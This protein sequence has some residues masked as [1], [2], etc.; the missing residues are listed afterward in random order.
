[1][2]VTTFATK[3]N[4]SIIAIAAAAALVLTSFAGATPANAA[5]PT[6]N[7]NSNVGMTTAVSDWTI[8]QSNTSG[9]AGLRGYS[10]RAEYRISDPSLI[11]KTLTLTGSVSGMA[12]GQSASFSADLTF[13]GPNDT[14]ARYSNIYSNQQQPVVV[15]A[16]TDSIQVLIYISASRGLD[17]VLLSSATMNPSFELKAGGVSITRNDVYSENYAGA[18][19]VLYLTDQPAFNQA[20]ENAEWSGDA[21][22]REV[23]QQTVTCVDISASSEGDELV[24]NQ[25]RDGAVSNLGNLSWSML[26]NNGFGGSGAGPVVL[27]AGM[28]SSGFMLKVLLY[29]TFTGASVTSG[30]HSS[31]VS[32]THNGVEV[33]APCLLVV[34]TVTPTLTYEAQS[35]NGPS[36]LFA[37]VTDQAFNSQWSWTVFKASDDSVL[38]SGT[39]FGSGRA[40]GLYSCG[41]TGC[42]QAAPPGVP[43]YVKVRKRGYLLSS[44]AGQL[45]AYSAYSQKSTNASIPDPWIS[46]TAPSAGS[47]PGDAKLVAGNIDYSAADFDPTMVNP[48]SSLRVASDGKNGV[49]RGIISVGEGCMSPNTACTATAK[50]LRIGAS[51]VDSTFATGGAT[52]LSIGSY[53]STGGNGFFPDSI[54]PAWYGARNKWSAVIRATD[55]SQNFPQFSYR[56]VTGTFASSTVSTPVNLTSAQLL[57]VCNTGSSGFTN[58]SLTAV[59]APT[60][61]PIFSLSCTRQGQGPFTVIGSRYVTI[62]ADGAVTVIAKLN[63]GDAVADTN[64]TTLAFVANVSASAASDVALTIVGYSLTVTGSGP[65]GYTGAIVARKAVQ[66]KVDGSAVTSNT[67]PYSSTAT[68]AEL[69]KKFVFSRTSSGESSKGFVVSTSNN[70]NSY[71]FATMSADGTITEGDALV[72]DSVEGLNNSSLSFVDGQD[73]GTTGK[74]QV[75][76]KTGTTLVAAATIDLDEKTIDTG[77]VVTYLNSVDP[78]V[79]TFTFLDPQGRVNWMFTSASSKLSL[80]RWNGVAGGGALP[81]GVTV[82]SVSTKFITNSASEV[83]IVGTGLNTNTDTAGKYTVGQSLVSA[84]TRTATKVVIVVPAGSVAGDI[85]IKGTFAGSGATLAAVTRVGA[86]KQAQSVVVTGNVSASWS[87]VNAKTVVTFPAATSVGLTTLVKVDKPAICSVSGQVVTMNAVGVC[88]VTVSSAGDLGTSSTSRATTLTVTRGNLALQSGPTLAVTNNPADLGPSDFNVLN[89]NPNVG[90]LAALTGSAVVFTYSSSDEGICTV[91]ENGNV[92]GIAVGFCVVTSNASAGTNWLAAAVTTTVTVT[93]STSIIPDSLPQEGDGV[94]APKAIVS[95]KNAYVLTN[96][97]SLLVKWDKKTGL[98]TLQSKGVYIGHI[99]AEV[100][101][102]KDGVSYTCVNVFGSTSAL[103]SK[104]AAQRKAAL[105]T[106]TF[107]ASSAACKDASRLNVPGVGGVAGTL[108]D[109]FSAIKKAAKDKKAAATVVGSAKYEALAFSKLKNFTGNVTIKL[110]RYR[111]WPTSMKNLTPGT[112]SAAKKIP[113]TVRLT[114]INLQ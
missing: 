33:S 111:A 103:A 12:A 91:D 71:N 31:G 22:F 92:T 8:G 97:S 67:T 85:E 60:S 79:I 110:T 114:S 88:V 25:I 48:G 14:N 36:G 90:S 105:K 69:E 54:Y 29:S 42:L 113:A 72:L 9:L 24:I 84:K 20:S 44:I 43:V 10:W 37:T 74:I 65:S 76:R 19:N 62:A 64:F 4:R 21:S 55:Y 52:G 6:P 47:N 87:G 46:A 11:G 32:V 45:Y 83:T 28:I 59:S 70:V 99:M 81:A 98:L 112:G 39:G 5:V 40:N 51:G 96:D 66:I 34:P 89:V 77:E 15:P 1:M 102:T 56:V 3:L 73:V 63:E 86:A 23:G 38:G 78:R 16:D 68:Q 50:L 17:S 104:T 101:F 53:T 35:M 75:L 80:V 93:D 41:L 57:T 107:T 26:D 30:G 49:L 13:F 7:A 2:F 27:D 58:A 95:N 109:N 108:A 94:L 82:T 100:T 61:V 18:T 106:K